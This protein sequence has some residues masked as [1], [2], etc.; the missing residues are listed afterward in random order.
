MRIDLKKAL[1]RLFTSPAFRVFLALCVGFLFLFLAVREVSWQEVSESIKEADPALIAVALIVTL[2]NIIMKI[3]RWWLLLRSP[4]HNTQ[5]LRL[6]SSFLTSQLLNSLAPVRLGDLSRVLV[7]PQHGVTSEGSRAIQP[8]FVLG[9]VIA[10]KYLDLLAYGFLIAVVIFLIP[11]PPGIHESLTSLAL[12]ALLGFCLLWIFFASRDF[13]QRAFKWL[14]RGFVGKIG[15]FISTHG[16]S[17]LQSLSVFQ[18]PRE[19]LGISFFTVLIWFSAL[20]TNV[21]VWEALDLDLPIEASILLLVALIAGISLPSLPG[22]V[23]TFE[24]A[25][26]LALGFFGLDRSTSLSYGILLHVVVYAPII[27]LGILS[28]WYLQMQAIPR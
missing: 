16:Q 11:L 8:G 15:V 5:L 6:S 21:I 24:Y 9:T 14:S 22:K 26:I 23:G 7:I 2:L 10:E 4:T 27:I 17:G 12:L 18:K 20:A 1:Q 3:I 13:L 25:S 19:I 28:T